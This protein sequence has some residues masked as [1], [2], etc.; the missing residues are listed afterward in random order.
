MASTKG[1]YMLLK[2]NEQIQSEKV[3]GP[4]RSRE[5]A[6]GFMWDGKL[7][8][9][10]NSGATV[11]FQFWHHCHYDDGSATWTPSQSTLNEWW[12]P[13]FVPIGPEPDSKCVDANWHTFY[14][15]NH[16]YVS[17][18]GTFSSSSRK[19]KY[20]IESIKNGSWK[21]DSDLWCIV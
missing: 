20:I 5:K 19:K 18:I 12:R 4:F 3:S 17:K 6:M 21:D 15:D 16:V 14:V 7:E 1:L 11:S 13:T 2:E 9:T 10:L 8:V